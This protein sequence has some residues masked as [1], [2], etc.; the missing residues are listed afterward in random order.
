M[1]VERF[2]ISYDMLCLLKVLIRLL[3]ALLATIMVVAKSF[4]G[5]VLRVLISA[6][7]KFVAIAILFA[8]CVSLVIMLSTPY[9]N[10]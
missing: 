7:V 6:A 1:E 3:C 2:L 5:C 10:T 8:G 4:T 9:Q